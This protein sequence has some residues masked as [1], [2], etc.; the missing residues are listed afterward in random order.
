MIKTFSILIILSL[1]HSTALANTPVRV[2]QRVVE[3]KATLKD[4][5]SIPESKK[6]KRVEKFNS[7]STCSGAFVSPNGH[8]LTAKHCTDDTL[9]IEVITY[10]QRRYKATIVAASKT[11][12]L[13]LIRIDR[14]KTPYFLLA[15]DS[16]RGEKV[17]ILGSPLGITDTLT[18]GI[19][20]RIDGD[21]TLVDCAALPGNSGGPVFNTNHEM[22]G[23]LTAGFI[24]MFGT[25]HLNIAQGLDSVTYFLK[26]HLNERR[27]P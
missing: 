2:E 1:V 18:T 27:R 12:D 24:V 26:E 23:V 15:Q 22:V 9:A 11:H 3:L 17:F 21:L 4:A 7:T 20:A 25:T 19:I 16:T 10:D 5:G 6:K 13:A 8:I 14:Q